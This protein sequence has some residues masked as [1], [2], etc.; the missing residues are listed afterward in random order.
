MKDELRAEDTFKGKGSPAPKSPLLARSRWT[1]RQMMLTWKFQLSNFLGI[2]W[3]GP[4][5]AMSRELAWS[6]TETG[7]PSLEVWPCPEFGNANCTTTIAR[8]GAHAADSESFQDWPAIGQFI[9]QHTLH[10][11]A[12]LSKEGRSPPKTLLQ[13]SLHQV[14]QSQCGSTWMLLP[15]ST[16]KVDWARSGKQKVYKDRRLQSSSGLCTVAIQSRLQTKTYIPPLCASTA[17]LRLG[18]GHVSTHMHCYSIPIASAKRSCQ[19]QSRRAAHLND[20]RLPTR[21]C[22]KAF[23]RALVSSQCLL[24]HQHSLMLQHQ[25]RF[26]H[27]SCLAQDLATGWPWAPFS[28]YA[29]TKC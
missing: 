13:L 26:P 8:I 23:S 19:S 25:K 28:R 17:P 24:L 20:R 2:W 9:D 16:L 3:W 21:Q 15:K 29:K 27:K 6:H 14:C 4:S 10:N 7:V 5:L 12:A 1:V 18:G 22:C 11:A